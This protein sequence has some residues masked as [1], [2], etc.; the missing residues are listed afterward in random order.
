M[1][2]RNS[3]GLND[4]YCFVISTEGR[5]LQNQPALGEH[6]LEESPGPGFSEL[7]IS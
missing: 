1:D 4:Y 7:P 3:G 5:D 2:G 6:R